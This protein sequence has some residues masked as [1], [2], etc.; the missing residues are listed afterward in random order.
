MKL[1]LVTPILILSLASVVSASEIAS[2]SLMVK[3]VFAENLRAT[4]QEDVDAIMSTMH[5]MS[6]NRAATKAQFPALFKRYD[7]KYE[8][9]DYSFVSLSGNY[10]IARVKQRTSKVKGPAFRNNIIDMLIVLKQDNGKWKLWSQAI[11]EI[12]FE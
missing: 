4:Q 11:L 5:S 3:E 8:L 2:P 12:K 1:N 6:P 7:L 9:V 10:A